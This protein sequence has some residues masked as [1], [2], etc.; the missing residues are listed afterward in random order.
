MFAFLLGVWV[1]VR[2]TNMV[3]ARWVEDEDG[4]GTLE[5]GFNGGDPA[6]GTDYYALTNCTFAEAEYFA[7][8][9]SKGGFWHDHVIKTG[10]EVLVILKTS[11]PSGKRKRP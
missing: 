8:A 11:T 10:R 3:E 4:S 2:S 1:K 7:Q 9:V 5:V 6:R